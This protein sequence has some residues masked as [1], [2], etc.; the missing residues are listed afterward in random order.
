MVIPHPLA[1]IGFTV[2]LFHPDEAAFAL[3]GVP[4]TH[5]I[6]L[7]EVCFDCFFFNPDEAAL[8]FAPK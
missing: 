1:V 2:L 8:I 3:K 7:W 5:P 6:L 4:F